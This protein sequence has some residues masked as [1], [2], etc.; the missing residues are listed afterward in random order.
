MIAGQLDRFVR[1][2]LPTWRE[3]SGARDAK[4]IVLAHSM[5]GL[6]ARYWATVLGGHEHCRTRKCCGI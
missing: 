2:A 1:R 5:G 6:I 3:Y 4:V